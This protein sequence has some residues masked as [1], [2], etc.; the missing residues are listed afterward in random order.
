MMTHIILNLHEEYQT[1]IEILEDKMEDKGNPITTERIFYK[2]SVKF[3]RMNKQSVPR[4]SV[5]DE[6]P[7]MQNISTRVPVQLAEDTDTGQNNSGIR[8]V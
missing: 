2:L 7:S 3:Y 1:I 8:K 4:T 6:K 5:E